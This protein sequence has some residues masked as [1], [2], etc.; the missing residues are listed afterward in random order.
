MK[1]QFEDDAAMVRMPNGCML[2]RSGRIRMPREMVWAIPAIVV[3]ELG[4]E[5][6]DS[7]SSYDS[8]VVVWPKRSNT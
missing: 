1:T 5:L 7:A 3:A 4:L 8:E 2:R 6:H